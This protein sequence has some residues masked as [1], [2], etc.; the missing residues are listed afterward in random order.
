MYFKE[1]TPKQ[2]TFDQRILYEVSGS[3]VNAEGIIADHSVTHQSIVSCN[4]RAVG[5]VQQVAQIVPVNL[6]REAHR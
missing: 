4:A 6:L 5:S 3:E 1:V 2:F